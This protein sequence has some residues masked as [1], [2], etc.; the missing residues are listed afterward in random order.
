MELS[1]LYCFA[2]FFGCSCF[3]VFFA[4]NPS[5]YSIIFG[6]SQRDGTIQLCVISEIL[7]TGVAEP[8]LK[9]KILGFFFEIW[10]GFFHQSYFL[11]QK[12]FEAYLPLVATL[13]SQESNRL[14]LI[15]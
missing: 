4:P 10:C 5:F 2:Q 14:N 12:W 15:K 13:L 8:S 6:L 7:V 11:V 3:G 1:P 9:S